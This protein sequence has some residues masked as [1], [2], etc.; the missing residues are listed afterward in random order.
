MSVDIPDEEY[1]VIY[2]SER[3][4]LPSSVPTFN[5]GFYV[6]CMLAVIVLGYCLVRA[7][8]AFVVPLFDAF[9]EHEA[10][11]RENTINYKNKCVNEQVKASYQGYDG[12]LKHEAVIKGGFYYPAFNLYKRKLDPC[13]EKGCL[14]V[15]MNAVSWLTLV[16]PLGFGIG[17]LLT[18]VVL[19]LI[20]VG[21]QRA[22]NARYEF[23]DRMPTYA[24]NRWSSAPSARTVVRRRQT[25]DAPPCSVG[26]Q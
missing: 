9:K 17:T 15:E 13:G 25:L 10:V 8:N 20:I 21:V 6:K 26:E 4:R 11:L 7:H 1:E 19:V 5:I 14:S 18:I 22:L 23:P 2:E 12:C 16:L 24:K 3:P